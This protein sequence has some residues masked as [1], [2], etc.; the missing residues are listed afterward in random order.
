MV[1]RWPGNGRAMVRQWSGA[2]QTMVGQWSGDGRAMV[3]QWSS[4]GRALSSVNQSALHCS[5]SDYRNNALGETQRTPWTQ[6][7]AHDCCQT[8][9]N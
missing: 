2:G 1:G 8:W 6:K 5:P 7:P 9:Q 4:N 3:G